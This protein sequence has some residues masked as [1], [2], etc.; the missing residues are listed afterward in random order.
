MSPQTLYF[1]LSLLLAFQQ[2]DKSVEL[3]L[4]ESDNR[5]IQAM[6]KSLARKTAIKSEKDHY[7]VG[8]LAVCLIALSCEAEAAE[9]LRSFVRYRPVRD[10]AEQNWT[11]MLRCL[12]L[13]ADLEKKNG[14]LAAH[15]KCMQAIEQHDYL[16]LGR[17][18]Y[19]WRFVRENRDELKFHEQQKYLNPM[20]ELVYIN[21]QYMEATLI[22]VYFLEWEKPS[23]IARI[24]RGRVDKATL[25]TEQRIL[26][27]LSY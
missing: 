1:Q 18:A 20:D 5:Y 10:L 27:L 7:R 17:A 4:P 15:D 3:C 2:R 23:L 11:W 13:L 25:A 16:D 14:D 12:V 19:I 24:L 26:D 21:F 22:R 9:L 6:V 8:E